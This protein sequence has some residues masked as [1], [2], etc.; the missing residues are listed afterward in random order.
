MAEQQLGCHAFGCLVEIA[1]QADD[2]IVECDHADDPMGLDHRHPPE[3]VG[4]EDCGD[5]VQFVVGADADDVGAHHEVDSR[6][7]GQSAGERSHH[8]VTVGDHTD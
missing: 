1:G 7:R 6:V 4:A 8:K 5:D 2:E 3:R